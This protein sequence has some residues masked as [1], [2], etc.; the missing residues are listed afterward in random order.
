MKL[1]L[2]A[3]CNNINTSNI[4][5]CKNRNE[6]F[7]F[8][9]KSYLIKIA[10]KNNL[11][12]D[13][14]KCFPNMKYKKMKINLFPKVD[15]IIFVD[16]KGLYDADYHFI[17]YLRKFAKYTVSTICKNSKYL[18]GEDIMFNYIKCNIN[19]DKIIN[20][21]PPCDTNL[22]NSRKEE[23]LIYI[24][25]NEPETV[26][27]KL[28]PM[29]AE[30]IK[31]LSELKTIMEDNP[32]TLFKIASINTHMIK[33]I[34]ANNNILD[35][36]QFK[37]YIDYIYELSSA[38]MYFMAD[39]CHDIYKLYELSMCNTLI[40]S[41]IKYINTS[42]KNELDIITFGQS[43][44]WEIIFERISEKVNK[45]STRIKLNNYTWENMIDIMIDSFTK[46][47]LLYKNDIIDNNN[48]LNKIQHINS[49][50]IAKIDT[51]QHIFIQP[52]YRKL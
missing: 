10:D 21:N 48:Q 13:V 46:H 35:T 14:I 40:I 30:R 32:T 17:H 50:N 47:M 12:V 52:M 15:H 2:L 31:I 4:E 43:V 7:V 45:C 22:Y 44:D 39:K 27:D 41:N 16:E 9:L 34:D 38:N 25:F 8:L 6:I 20:V 29:I 3:N 33:I 23:G 1:L 18:A 42:I 26:F 24:L 28:H 5:D 37:S 36:I 19:N 49:N 51:S 11:E